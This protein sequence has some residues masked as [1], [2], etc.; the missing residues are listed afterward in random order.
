MLLVAGQVISAAVGKANIVGWGQILESALSVASKE[1]RFYIDQ[2]G[3]SQGF[4]VFYKVDWKDP[5]LEV[6]RP[7]KKLFQKVR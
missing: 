1:V 5:S 7:L 2:W 3:M 4:E 6:I